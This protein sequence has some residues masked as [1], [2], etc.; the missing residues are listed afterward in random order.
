MVQYQPG[1]EIRFR[2]GG[3]RTAPG[4]RL[5]LGATYSMFG[6]DEAGGF[7]YGTGDRLVT[8]G[9]YQF[10]LGP[11]TSLSLFAWDLYRFEGE[12][13]GDA[14]APAENIANLALALGFGVAGATI[15]PN[16]E[17]RFATSDDET[18]R[19]Q[20]TQLGLRLRRPLGRLEIYPSAAYAIGKIGAEDA[21]LNGFRAIL[22]MRF[23]P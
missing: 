9:G 17:A 23:T 5:S 22:T 11:T 3:D 20:L 12:L 2:V 10:N 7:T 13:L 19:G 4:G 1:N 14:V 18:R 6:D 21:G 8:Q 15:E 16:V